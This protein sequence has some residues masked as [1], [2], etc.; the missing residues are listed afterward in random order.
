VLLNLAVFGAVLSYALQM[1]SF[2]L[3]RR[4]LGHLQRPF[5][6]PHLARGK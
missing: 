5:R 6:S 3:L 4:R 2:V 1:L